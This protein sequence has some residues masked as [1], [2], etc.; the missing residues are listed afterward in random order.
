MLR[1]IIIFLL[2]LVFVNYHLLYAQLPPDDEYV[3]VG[4]DGHLYLKGKRIHF[5]GA[6][7][8]VPAMTYADNEAM[9]KR[10]KAFGFNMFRYGRAPGE[11]TKGDGSETDRF[12]HFLYCCKKEGI[13]VWY[14]GLNRLTVMK[15]EDAGIIN[16]PGIN[17]EWCKAIREIGAGRGHCF[18]GVA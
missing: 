9:V 16:E 10:L 5:W 12:D 7:G 2:A 3:T 8:N 1:S 18:Y 14:T 13:Y 4:S 15:S 11:Y 6:I 17:S